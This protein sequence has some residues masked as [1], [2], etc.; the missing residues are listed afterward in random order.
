MIKIERK[1]LFLSILIIISFITL[2]DFVIHLTTNKTPYISIEELTNLTENKQVRFRGKV[3]DYG[4]PSSIFVEEKGFVASVEN[5]PISKYR[6][7]DLIEVEG[8]YDARY[9]LI[10]RDV[11]Y[12]RI[13]G[14]ENATFTFAEVNKSFI[15]MENLGKLIKI[16]NQTLIDYRETNLLIF[17]NF[18]YPSYIDKHKISSTFLSPGLKYDLYGVILSFNGSLYLRLLN[19]TRTSGE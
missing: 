4:V 13:L 19:I 17:L 8:Y 1:S 9:P 12:V 11:K 3:L 6:I 16:K 10:F 15:R 14:H 7:G 2:I 5:I 18:S